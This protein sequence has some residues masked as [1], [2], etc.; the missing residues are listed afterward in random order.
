MSY[1]YLRGHQKLVGKGMLPLVLWNV[2][3]REND[4]A[5]NPE[6]R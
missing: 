3:G 4:Q 5:P 1:L 2:K 6:V